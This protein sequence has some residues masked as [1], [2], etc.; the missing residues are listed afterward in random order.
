MKI[1]RPGKT[2]KCL[3]SGR[4]YLAKSHL[5]QHPG[6]LRVFLTKNMG[7]EDRMLNAGIPGS[8]GKCEFRLLPPFRYWWELKEISG[9]DELNPSKGAAIVPYPSGYFFKFVE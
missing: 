1:K 9:D 7:Q 2:L 6:E 3:N 5:I 4:A 8:G